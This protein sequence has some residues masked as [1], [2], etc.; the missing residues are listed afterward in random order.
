MAG[1][2]SVYEYKGWGRKLVWAIKEGSPKRVR[3]I[4]GYEMRNLLDERW[5]EVGFNAIVPVPVTESKLETQ[6]FNHAEL[7]AKPLSILMDI[8]IY[9]Y[10]LARSWNSLTQRDLGKVD[11]KENA[12]LSYKAGLTNGLTG[13]TILLVDDLLT[14]GCTLA[15]CADRLL[16]SG[17]AKV[18]GLT[19]AA[20]LSR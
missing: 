18:Y 3:Y 8:P 12:E 16:D 17:A 7:L 1:V 14:T 13:K 6:G 4:L 5:N 20:T 15:A 9:P 10:A 19:A 11:R 2:A